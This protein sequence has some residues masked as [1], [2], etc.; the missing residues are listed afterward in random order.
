VRLV[1]GPYWASE[2][3]MHRHRG[4]PVPVFARK[5]DTDASYE[6]LI[7][8]LLEHHAVIRPAFG[9]HNLRHVAMVMAEV[10]RRG[11]AANVVELQM[12]YGMA[13][14]LQAAIVDG[15]YRVRVHAQGGHLILGL[16]YVVRR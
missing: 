15:G 16:A 8:L 4:W 13:E 11:L 1:N 7:P 9:T 2:T 5:D 6:Q 3:I 12:L 10:E 14:P